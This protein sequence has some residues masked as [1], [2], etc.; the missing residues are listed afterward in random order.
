[1]RI[2][3][4]SEDSLI[5]HKRSEPEAKMTKKLK[6]KLKLTYYCLELIKA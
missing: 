4:P 3:K 6:H 1:M 2:R 5:S